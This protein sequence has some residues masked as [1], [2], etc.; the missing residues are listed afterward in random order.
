MDISRYIGIPHRVRGRD[1]SA[2]DC[3][4]LIHLFYKNE[5]GIE[6]PDYS[7]LYDEPR[8]VKQVEALVD[9][10]KR[11]FECISKPEPFA[12][13]LMSFRHQICHLGIVI[14]GIM[15]S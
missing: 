3:W 10:E 12:I 2:L 11:R 13:I 7:D 8:D 4:G 14:D 1:E 15:T 9:I 6:L 5:L